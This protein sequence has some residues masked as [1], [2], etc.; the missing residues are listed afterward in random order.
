MVSPR[1][2]MYAMRFSM[3][4]ALDVAA[5]FAPQTMHLWAPLDFGAAIAYAQ[6]VWVWKRE[7][8]VAMTGG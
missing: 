1:V 5:H 8:R 2:R 7:R 3:L 4:L 6:T